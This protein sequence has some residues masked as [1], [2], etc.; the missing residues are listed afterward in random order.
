MEVLHVTYPIGYSPQERNALVCQISIAAVGI[1][2]VAIYSIHHGSRDGG[3]AWHT[4]ISQAETD[5][6]AHKAL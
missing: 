3:G 4:G 6:A 1:I 2:G 5:A